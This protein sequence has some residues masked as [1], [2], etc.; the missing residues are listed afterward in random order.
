MDAETLF[1]VCNV[2]VLPFWA[3]L[4]LAPGW[5]WTRRLVHAMW[6]PL[7]LAAT[8]GIAFLMGP[9]LPEEAGFG[10]LPAVMAFFSVPEA[11]LAGWIHYL[12]FD[13]FVGAWEVRDARRRGLPHAAVIPCLVLTLLLGPLGLAAYLLL[14]LALARTASLVETPA[15]AA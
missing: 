11:A 12:V 9:G 13:L 14:R 5:L 2:G 4:V 7:A 3:L 8:Y 10:S 15:T 6:I 1:T